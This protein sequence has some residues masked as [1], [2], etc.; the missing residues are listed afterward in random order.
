MEA[1]VFPPT[2]RRWVQGVDDDR[3]TGGL[4]VELDGG[5]EHVGHERGADAEAAVA[6]V[7]RE[8]AD[9]QRRDGVGRVAR[10]AGW[11]GRA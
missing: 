9:Q 3:A 5:S 2:P 4:S 11:R 7:D 1:E 10:D 6:L 8:S